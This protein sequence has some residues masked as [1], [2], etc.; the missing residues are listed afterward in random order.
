MFAKRKSAFSVYSENKPVEQDQQEKNSVSK[1][2][3]NSEVYNNMSKRVVFASNKKSDQDL[4]LDTQNFNKN[5]ANNSQSKKKTNKNNKMKKDK[6]KFA[7]ILP[8]DLKESINMFNGAPI[9][10]QISNNYP[11]KQSKTAIMSESIKNSSDYKKNNNN[12]TKVKN[13][14]ELKPKM[15]QPLNQELI[16]VNAC[17]EEEDERENDLNVDDYYDDNQ[18]FDSRLEATKLFKTIISPV[19]IKPFFNTYWEKK[20]MLIKRQ[21][22]GYYNSW[23]SCKEFDNILKKVGRDFF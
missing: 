18:M 4:K 5:F 16:Y 15:Q 2:Y 21:E 7:K 20:P 9:K 1:K 22:S 19:K 12:V 14:S 11:I 10:N 8:N 3:S 6:K 17:Q 13:T 23:F